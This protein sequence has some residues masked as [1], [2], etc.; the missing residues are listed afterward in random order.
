VSAARV[1]VGAYIIVL[2]SNCIVLLSRGSCASDPVQGAGKAAIEVIEKASWRV[3][4]E[5]ACK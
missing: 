1:L 2:L 4:G 5:H 3:N